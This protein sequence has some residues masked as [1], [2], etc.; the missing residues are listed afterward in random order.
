M[1]GYE[2]WW[3]D[4]EEEEYYLPPN[5]HPY[6][7]PPDPRPIHPD[8]RDRRYRVYIF[9]YRLYPDDP[10]DPDDPDNPPKY[11]HFCVRFK[12]TNDLDT[13][14][15]GYES[16]DDD[17]TDILPH[18]HMV[19]ELTSDEINDIGRMPFQKESGEHLPV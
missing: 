10:D 18:P 3:S 15:S 4:E 16:N 2:G 19:M 13:P 6:H 7:C 5:V 14:D 1:A 17:A 11:R 8:H 12:E 9:R